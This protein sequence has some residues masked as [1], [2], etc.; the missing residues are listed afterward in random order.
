MRKYFWL[1][2]IDGYGQFIAEDTVERILGKSQRLRGMHVVHVS[3]TFYGRRCG[4][5]ALIGNP[6]RPQPR[7]PSRLATDPEQPGFFQRYE[8]DSPRLAGRRDQPHG[9]KER[10][11]RDGDLAR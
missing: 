8:E 7:N 10:D 11:L 6:A 3:F 5:I 4:R 1:V 2:S 9:S